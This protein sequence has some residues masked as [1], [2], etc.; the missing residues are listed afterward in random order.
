[1][2]K[3]KIAILCHENAGRRNPEKY[4]ISLLADIWR[5]DGLD[6]FY[7]FGVKK[8]IPADLAIIH[9][10]LSVVLDEYLEFAHRYPVVLNG[11]VKDIRKS[12]FSRNIVK[13][14]DA[15]DGKVIVKSILNCAGSAERKFAS[16]GVFPFVKKYIRPLRFNKP[17]DYIIYDH[18]NDIPHKYFNSDHF[19][20]E[21]FLPEMEN[22]CYFVRCY[23][24]LGSRG[25]CIR[26]K[27][28]QPI[29][30]SKTYQSMEFVEPHPEII[31]QCERLQFDYGKF[32]YVIHDGRVV[33][34]DVNKTTGTGRI[35]LDPKME[36]L[37]RIRAAAIY[38]YLP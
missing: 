29:V 27:S 24:F 5:Q 8:F 9:V 2:L 31:E 38:S 33:L 4:A 32:D 30:N 22:D 35:V 21:K 12:F 7:V 14:N 34:L 16:W 20:V 25:T 6:V 19:V 26:L 3:K 23:H 10:D 28:N 37:R 18:R 36:K 1:M 13:K 15:Y 17:T 11:K